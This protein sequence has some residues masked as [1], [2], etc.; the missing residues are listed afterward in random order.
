MQTFANTHICIASLRNENVV[1]NLSWKKDLRSQLSLVK[2]GGN[3]H[4]NYHKIWLSLVTKPHES[5]IFGG[6]AEPVRPLCWPPHTRTIPVDFN[7]S[8]A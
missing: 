3:P 8:C 5:K 7:G 2:T 6:Q 4:N 1:L